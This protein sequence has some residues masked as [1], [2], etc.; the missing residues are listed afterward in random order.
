MHHHSNPENYYA[1][2]QAKLSHLRNGAP[3]TDRAMT[4]DANEPLSLRSLLPSIVR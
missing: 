1:R 3:Y 2:D 4:P